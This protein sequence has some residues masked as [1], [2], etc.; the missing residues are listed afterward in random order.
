VGAL[1]PGEEEASAA[2]GSAGEEMTPGVIEGVS[3]SGGPVGSAS[4]AAEPTR[5]A[6]I[7]AA[8]GCASEGSPEP[9][10]VRCTG[11]LG[12]GK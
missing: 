2:R 8:C 4:S 11:P 3:R 1:T 7:A 6:P 5:L 12:A 10:R 9:A